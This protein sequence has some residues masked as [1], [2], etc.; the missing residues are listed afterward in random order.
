VRLPREG[1]TPGTGSEP[2]D[3]M[4]THTAA[5][6]YT[7]EAARD[8]RSQVTR[9]LGGR[10]SLATIQTASLLTSELATNA[11]LHAAPPVHLHAQI[12]EASIRVEV[13]DGGAGTSPALRKTRET[14][15]GGRGL[16]IIEALASRWGAEP[17]HGGKVVWFE[18]TY[19]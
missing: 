16:A 7:A 3:G 12:T 11:V 14:D 19:C 2:T 6:P 13:P 9:L 4:I 8:A 1:Y 17:T 18:L 10:C 5:L 15:H